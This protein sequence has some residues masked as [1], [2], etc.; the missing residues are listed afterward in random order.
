MSPIPIPTPVVWTTP[1]VHIAGESV[2]LAEWN[3]LAEDV[4][5]LYAKPWIKSILVAGSYALPNNTTPGAGQP[6][7]GDTPQTVTDLINSPP[8]GVG[9]FSRDSSGEILVPDVPGLY[10]IRVRCN[11]DP[12]GAVAR[13]SIRY[14]NSG[15]VVFWDM[16]EWCDI[17]SGDKTTLTMASD[18]P[19]RS[20]A[21]QNLVSFA[22]CGQADGA[23]IDVGAYDDAGHTPTTSPAYNFTEVFCQWVGSDGTY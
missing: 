9:S 19:F 18:V 20:G 23:G 5:L 17:S 8:S 6:L 7:F 16:G 13:L 4:A 14:S 10:R 15:G 1:V 22:V 12:A 21:F 3:S 11:T 2:D